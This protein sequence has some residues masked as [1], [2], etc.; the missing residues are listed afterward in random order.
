MPNIY[1][2]IRPAEGGKDSLLFVSDLARAYTKLAEKY[3]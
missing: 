1:I 2:E 3:Q